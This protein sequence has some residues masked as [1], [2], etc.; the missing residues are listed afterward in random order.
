MQVNES[1]ETNQNISEENSIQ[2]VFENINFEAQLDGM[3]RRC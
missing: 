1:I 2:V 3:A